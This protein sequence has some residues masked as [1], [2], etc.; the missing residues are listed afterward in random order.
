MALRDAGD[1]LPAGIVA[2]SPFIDCALKG[3]AIH[4][5]NGEDPIVEIDTLAY[6]VSSYFQKHSPADPLVSPIYGDFRGLPPM[7]IQ[8]GRKEVLVDE[9]LGLEARAKAQG[10][11]A[12][13]E[14]YD[15]RLHIFSLFPFLPSAARALDSIRVFMLRPSLTRA[16]E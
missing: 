11:T 7:L 5:R 6:M 10:V 15:E 14:L 1:K 9:A 16:V 12:T 13:L 8:A 4:R 3:E 2:L